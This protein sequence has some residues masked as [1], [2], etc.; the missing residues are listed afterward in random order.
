VWRLKM[1]YIQQQKKPYKYFIQIKSGS[2]V[3]VFLLFNQKINFNFGWGGG[4]GGGHG[5]RKT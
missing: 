2:L 5:H 3:F 1:M 4:R